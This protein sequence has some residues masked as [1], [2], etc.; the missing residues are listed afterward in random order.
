MIDRINNILNNNIDKI[1]LNKYDVS[2]SLNDYQNTG[3]SIEG[4]SNVL[5]DTL[6]QKY[7]SSNLL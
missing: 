5:M 2:I 7:K 1:N 4:E 3:S 6:L